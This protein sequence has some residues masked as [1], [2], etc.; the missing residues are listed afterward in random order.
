[1]CASRYTCSP[2][3]LRAAATSRGRISGTAPCSDTTPLSMNWTSCYPERE[4]LTNTR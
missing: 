4:F 1:M 3:R 2:R